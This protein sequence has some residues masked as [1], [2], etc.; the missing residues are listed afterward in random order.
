M[1]IKEESIMRNNRFDNFNY[2]DRMAAGIFLFL[3]ICAAAALIS[4]FLPIF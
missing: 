4:R 3:V 2:T 1:S